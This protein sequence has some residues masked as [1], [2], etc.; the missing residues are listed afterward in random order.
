[1]NELFVPHDESLELKRLGF[2][3]ETFGYWFKDRDEKYYVT[4][5][6]TSFTKWYINYFNKKAIVLAP[7]YQQAFKWFRDKHKIDSYIRQIYIC[8]EKAGYTIFI[9]Q[10]YT[11]V[12]YQNDYGSYFTTYEEAELACINFL[13][14]IVKSC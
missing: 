5:P 1:M 4:Y 2:E 9:E 6:K 13:I 11:D 8:G 10:Q 12:M 14:Q 7:T 3:E